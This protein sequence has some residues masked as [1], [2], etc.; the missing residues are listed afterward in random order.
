[1]KWIYNLLLAGMAMACFSSCTEDETTTELLTKGKWVMTAFTVDPA[2]DWFGSQVTN[3]YS[4]LDACVKDDFTIFKTDGT[5]LYD[6][7]P[8]KCYGTDPQ[9]RTAKWVLNPD[10]TIIS[11]TEDGE[12]ESWDLKTLDD[13]VFKVRYTDTE[14]VTTYT[15]DITFS[16]IQ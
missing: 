14:G 12:T 5:V 6:E 15:F 9:T 10:E 8:S 7:G 3:I 13:S 4:Q 2:V 16:R 1:M 11:L